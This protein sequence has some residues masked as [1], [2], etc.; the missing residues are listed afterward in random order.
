MSRVASCEMNLRIRN[1]RSRSLYRS[2]ALSYQTR[3]SASRVGIVCTFHDVL[4]IEVVCVLDGKK[5]TLNDV[6]AR[7]VIKHIRWVHIFF[8][9]L[10]GMCISGIPCVREE[11]F[12]HVDWVI[13]W[14]IKWVLR[15]GIFY[16]QSTQVVQYFFEIVRVKKLYNVGYSTRRLWGYP[17]LVGAAFEHQYRNSFFW[18]HWNSIWIKSFL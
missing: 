15:S 2:G 16:H 13:F 11:L 1:E 10:A 8:V 3:T 12:K 5:C 4:L 9:F 17:V 6:Q 7:T 14:S 18:N